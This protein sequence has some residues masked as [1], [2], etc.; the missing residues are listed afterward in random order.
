MST[1]T[2]RLPLPDRD[3]LGESPVWDVREGALY[4]VDTR[5][6]LVKRWVEGGPVRSW[7]TPSD[8]GSIALAAPGRLVLSL[9]DGF[10]WLDLASGSV[11]RIADVVHPKP[12]M[13]LRNR[14]FRPIAISVTFA[15]KQK[16]HHGCT[17][18]P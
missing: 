16:F 13:R 17:G 10:A 1:P 5:S 15:A 14:L 6:R 18:S 4:W 3:L 7:A 8:V 11:E 12:A 2:A 9:E